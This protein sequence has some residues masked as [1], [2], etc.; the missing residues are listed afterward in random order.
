MQPL[1]QKTLDDIDKEDRIGKRVLTYSEE[2]MF[3]L[4]RCEK[5]LQNISPLPVSYDVCAVQP[6]YFNEFTY[7][8]I[9]NYVL[10]APMNYE[11]YVRFLVENVE[12]DVNV[13]EYQVFS[14]DT[15]KDKYKLLDLG[16]TDFE[17]VVFLPGS[18]YMFI[19]DM[20]KLDMLMHYNEGML[21]KPHPITSQEDLKR[22]GQRYGYH[23]IIE[24]TVSGYQVLMACDKIY[25]TENS[26]IGMR[27]ILNGI[28][29]ESIAKTSLNQLC[30]YFPIYFMLNRHKTDGDKSLLLKTLFSGSYGIINID[31][32]KYEIEDKLGHYFS[33]IM[34][35]RERY[36]PLTLPFDNK[37]F[38][39][40]QPRKQKQTK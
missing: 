19:V 11:M 33:G 10:V 16:D 29:A 22:L 36:K 15:M 32:N 21:I 1:N 23:R 25:Y 20:D 12:L 4:K 27:A 17:E 24:S 28:K 31:W 9:E 26:E 14:K 35:L 34:G 6:P 38:Y 5:I 18:N 30:L 40:Y 2:D 39:S 8:N 3:R 37:T 7:T 13:S